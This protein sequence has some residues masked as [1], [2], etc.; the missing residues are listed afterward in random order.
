MCSDVFILESDA[1]ATGVGA[2]LYVRKEEGLQPVAF[3]SRQ[4]K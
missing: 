3:L 2:V 1:S 4:L